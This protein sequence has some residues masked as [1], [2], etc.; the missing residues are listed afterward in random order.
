MVITG[1]NLGNGADITNVT[2]CGVSAFIQNQQGEAE[3]RRLSWYSTVTDR[4]LF[5]NRRGQR[6]AELHMDALARLMAQ[7]QLR[8]VDRHQL[9]LIDRAFRSTVELLRNTL[10]GGDESKKA[11]QWKAPVT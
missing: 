4:A 6:V 7:G 2:V 1:T 5:V 11:K 10:R 9:R 8:V 3:R